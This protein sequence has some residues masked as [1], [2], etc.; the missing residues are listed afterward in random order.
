MV[1]AEQIE[2]EDLRKRS[3][4]IKRAKTSDGDFSHL[5][6]NRHGR[7]KFQQ[8]FKVKVPPIIYILN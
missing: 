3:M 8:C 7:S 1:H 4:E 6:S 2:E 5:G